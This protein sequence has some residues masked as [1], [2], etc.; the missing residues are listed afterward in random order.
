MDVVVQRPGYTWVP[1]VEYWTHEM[2]EEVAQ[3]VTRAWRTF[4]S[5][6]LQIKKLKQELLAVID[7][8]KC[9]SSGEE[10]M[11]D[12]RGSYQKLTGSS[13]WR[14]LCLSVDV[15]SP[16]LELAPYLGEGV[17]LKEVRACLNRSPPFINF[18]LSDT[19]TVVAFRVLQHWLYPQFKGILTVPGRLAKRPS[20]QYLSGH[21]KRRKG[22]DEDTNKEDE[23]QNSY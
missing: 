4:H 9:I 23:A 22:K 15:D 10:I 2:W 12:R 18:P 19:E 5:V 6:Q 3:Y 21:A 14:R 11:P 20:T 17:D 16:E 1:W 8:L 13:K 7:D